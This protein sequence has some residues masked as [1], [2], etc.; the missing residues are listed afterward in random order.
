MLINKKLISKV[1]NNL[2][3]RI[4]QHNANMAELKPNQ[5]SGF[6]KLKSEFPK[7]NSLVSGNEG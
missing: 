7:K 5:G 1:V 6:S 4:Q 2:P 3:S